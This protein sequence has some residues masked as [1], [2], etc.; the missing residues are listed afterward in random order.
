MSPVTY[1]LH[2]KPPPF[3]S[4]GSNSPSCDWDPSQAAILLRHALEF[5]RSRGLRLLRQRRELADLRI[6]RELRSAGRLHVLEW[7]R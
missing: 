5:A 1:T 6:P 2:A 4:A 7:E 3:Q